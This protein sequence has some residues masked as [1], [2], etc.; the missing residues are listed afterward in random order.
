V[1]T[2]LRR[3]GW[4]TGCALLVVLFQSFFQQP[5]EP[6]LAAAVLGLAVLSGVAPFAGLQVLAGLGPLAGAVM[7][8]GRGDAR[9]INLAEVLVL[10][11]LSGWTARQAVTATPLRLPPAV[12]LPA[13]LLALAALTS[14]AVDSAGAS[15]ELQFEPA[16]EMVQRYI[17]NY[18]R[19]AAGGEPLRASAQLACGMLLVLAAA[20]ITS[21]APERRSV[22]LRMMVCGAAAAALLNLSRIVE[23]V[24]TREEHS[25]G[26]FLDAMLT[27]RV[28][29]QYADRNAAGS[30]FALALMIAVAVAR[31]T[32]ALAAV[33]GPVVAASLWITGS[34]FALAATVAATIGG[35]L[36]AM[37]GARNIRRRLVALTVIGAVLISAAIVWSRYPK[38][39]NIT[40]R[41]AFGIRL[42]LTRAGIQMAAEAPVFG[43]GVGR[44]YALSDDYAGEAL[45]AA[46]FERENAHNNFIQV[47]AELGVPGL[48][49]L[50]TLVGA[51]L[52]QLHGHPDRTETLW[53]A[54][55]LSAYLLT[56]LGGHPLLVPDAA[57]PFWLA[58]GLAAAPEAL[59]V[60][61]SS[62]WKYAAAAFAV[63]LTVSVWPRAAASVR[64]ADLAGT[65]GGLSGWQRE[66]DGS[67]YRWAGTRS[68]FYVP[69]SASAVRIP[70]QH[71][72]SD[73][74]TIEVAILVEGR[75]ADRVMLPADDRWK[76][77]RIL[78]P[79]ESVAAFTRFDLVASRAG[80]R[81]PL[82]VIP[83]E[84]SGAIKVGRV[85]IDR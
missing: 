80:E 12:R 5:I 4:I 46:G 3:A 21:A 70:L 41:Q 68:T 19:H 53:L 8:L 60:A 38:G 24:L 10:A 45:R 65:S 71:G 48:L 33:A 14:V 39:R 57:T 62:R 20:H 75:E 63:F 49:L 56:C 58:L 43:V 69:S 83:T 59:P 47:L 37:H 82:A 9:T 25:L 26:T 6:V 15:T 16:G 13:L 1:S 52:Q 28:N 67:R 22:V 31:R 76:V 54:A 55:G 44:Y 66:P 42:D 27:Y 7:V 85:E 77:V 78:L 36:V 61:Q 2:A 84:D 29:T 23:V 35:L 81:V 51:S 73:R 74:R 30:H 18:V 40:A 34:R 79:A 11:F 50:L 72:W 17:H 32:P 64:H